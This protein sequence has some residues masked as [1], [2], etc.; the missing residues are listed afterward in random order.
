[1]L[2]LQVM[3][4]QLKRPDIRWQDVQQS[5]QMVG[6]VVGVQGLARSERDRVLLDAQ[7]RQR[8]RQE[9][10]AKVGEVVAAVIV[11]AVPWGVAV[12]A[13]TRYC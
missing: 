3:Q 1:M 5:S 6:C 2:C 13:L 7:R 11:A 8:Q 10:A 4:Q 9:S 12:G